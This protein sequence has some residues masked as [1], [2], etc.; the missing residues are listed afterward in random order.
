[1]RKLH[2]AP[3]ISGFGRVHATVERT[4]PLICS[5]DPA[6][7]HPPEY[8][9]DDKRISDEVR[10][11][12]SAAE[13]KD[14]AGLYA[15]SDAYRA[16]VKDTEDEEV[17][18]FKPGW[19]PVRWYFRCLTPPEETKF[20]DKAASLEDTDI[21]RRAFSV[22]VLRVTVRAVDNWPTNFGPAP[23]AGD[24]GYLAPTV[25]DLLGS[26]YLRALSDV[27]L[28]YHNLTDHEKKAFDSQLSAST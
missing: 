14:L 23:V 27:V 2:T 15:Q 7:T 25:W 16:Y 9:D 22:E 11:S 10:G 8:P 21:A 26:D 4:F 5:K 20:A 12:M 19:A 24:K 28:G 3:G 6:L 1:M 17:L 13:L 18:H